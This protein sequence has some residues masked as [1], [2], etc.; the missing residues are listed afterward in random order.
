MVICLYS[1]KDSY[2]GLFSFNLKTAVNINS[3][4][5]WLFLKHKDWRFLKVDFC[6]LTIKYNNMVVSLLTLLFLVFHP[7]A[8][9]HRQWWKL[10]QFFWQYRGRTFGWHPHY[11]FYQRWCSCVGGLQ[12]RAKPTCWQV[13]TIHCGTC[14]PRR[15]LLPKVLLPQRWAK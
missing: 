2:L 14:W 5:F 4:T 8:R 6:I 11:S 7:P 13:Q 1:W 9:K 15:L 10:K 12:G 3:L